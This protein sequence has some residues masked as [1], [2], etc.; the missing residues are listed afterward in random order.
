MAYN[1]SP[2]PLT[3]NPV[4]GSLS[5]LGRPAFGHQ[6]ENPAMGYGVS[7]YYGFPMTPPASSFPVQRPM[8]YQPA[9]LSPVAPLSTPGQVFI[10]SNPLVNATAPVAANAQQS[11]SAVQNYYYNVSGK[12]PPSKQKDFKKFMFITGAVMTGMVATMGLTILGLRIKYPNKFNFFNIVG[13]EPFKWLADGAKAWN[14]TEGTNPIQRGLSAFKAFS[15]AYQKRPKPVQKEAGYLGRLWNAIM[16]KQ[17]PVTT[18][19]QVQAQQAAESKNLLSFLPQDMIDTGKRVQTA[20]NDFADMIGVAKKSSLTESLEK[21]PE[22]LDKVHQMATKAEQDYTHFSKEYIPYVKESVTN[23]RQVSQDALGLSGQAKTDYASM[24]P[25][26]KATVSKAKSLIDTVEP[27]V[28][29]TI[30]NFKQVSQDAAGLS[31]QAKTDYASMVP[32]AKAT[33]SKAKTLIDT[34]EPQVQET[35]GNFKQ[36]SQGATNLMTQ[37]RQDYSDTMPTVQDAAQNVSQAAKKGKEIADAAKVE[38]DQAMPTVQE[39]VSNFKQVSDDAVGLSTKA[40]K[41]YEDNLPKIEA[42]IQNAADVTSRPFSYLTGWGAKKTP[43]PPAP[44]ATHN[45]IPGDF[46]GNHS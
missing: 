38:F 27:Q 15:E 10:R 22:S 16:N 28:Q 6:V 23:F 20:L 12:T 29:E 42:A 46:P 19:A 34:V 37:V 30:G 4:Y 45:E 1:V 32:D 3:G 33:V 36:V 14:R 8:S 24:V 7:A 43:A 39:T 11:G 25:D 31:T 40:K 21:L 13:E 5:M 44:L 17:V 18:P 9:T 2:N 26:A 41:D 35:V